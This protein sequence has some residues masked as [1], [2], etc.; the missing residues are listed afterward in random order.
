MSQANQP[1]DA[2][3]IQALIPKLR[4]AARDLVDS[5]G[6]SPDALVQDALLIALRNWNGL[7]SGDGLEPWLLGVLRDPGLVER[8]Q[9]LG[10]ATAERG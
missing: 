2:A 10:P 6:I 9:Q 7:P 5:S 8:A 4:I 3:A 1:I